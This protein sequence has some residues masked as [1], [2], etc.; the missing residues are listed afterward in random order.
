M[1][2]TVTVTREWYCWPKK[3]E[4]STVII[5]IFDS[6]SDLKSDEGTTCHCWHYRRRWLF[7]FDTDDRR[8]VD[9][10]TGRMSTFSTWTFH[11]QVWNTLPS[12]V[13][14][15]PIV[16]SVLAYF[17]HLLIYTHQVCVCWGRGCS[18]RMSLLHQEGDPN[19][20]VDR[21]KIYIC[22][23]DFTKCL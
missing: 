23:E 18:G 11:W 19:V 22:V 10:P 4:N 8:R 6:P 14:L 3:E 1:N 2:E 15:T 21:K 7:Q 12:F 20:L 9:L 13:R 16:V 5:P 17:S